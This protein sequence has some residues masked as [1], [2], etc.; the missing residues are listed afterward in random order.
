VDSAV[1]QKQQMFID[2][3]EKGSDSMSKRKPRKQSIFDPEDRYR[4]F[5]GNNGELLDYTRFHPRRQYSKTN[6]LHAEGLLVSFL[7]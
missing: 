7:Q 2:A 3:S 6:L 4:I 5:F 1:Q